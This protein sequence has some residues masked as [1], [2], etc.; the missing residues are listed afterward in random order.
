MLEMLSHFLYW[1]LRDLVRMID[2]FDL[3]VAL[4]DMLGI[5]VKYSE[6]LQDHYSQYRHVLIGLYR[7]CSPSK[8]CILVWTKETE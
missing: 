3:M 6:S 7:T 2:N 1:M 8:K 5:V 4:Q